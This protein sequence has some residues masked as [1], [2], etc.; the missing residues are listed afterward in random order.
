MENEDSL[1]ASFN[2]SGQKYDDL[3][4]HNIMISEWV[5]FKNNKDR[6]LE[7]LIRYIAI[8]RT[9]EDSGIITSVCS[10]IRNYVSMTSVTDINN[11]MFLVERQNNIKIRLEALKM[12]TRKILCN[13]PERPVSGEDSVGI[14]LEGIIEE[15]MHRIRDRYIGSIVLDSILISILTLRKDNSHRIIERILSSGETWFCEVVEDQLSMALNE[16]KSSSVSSEGDERAL[17]IKDMIEIIMSH[18]VKLNSNG[19]KNEPNN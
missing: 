11:I 3:Y 10:A 17:F 4:H 19:D 6:M 2:S 12:F 14:L 7:I 5:E 9:S 18:R 13:Q 16:L 15:N 1:I 8:N